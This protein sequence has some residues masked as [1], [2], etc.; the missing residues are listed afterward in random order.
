[1]TLEP[2]GTEDRGASRRRVA[3]HNLNKDAK[4]VSTR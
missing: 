1:L 4:V 2:A 3:D